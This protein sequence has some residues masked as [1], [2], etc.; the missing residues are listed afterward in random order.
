MTTPI[1]VHY[2]AITDT[3][4]AVAAA[5]A[6]AAE[7]GP[8]PVASGT[9][10]VDAAAAAVAAQIAQN[11]AAFSAALAPKGPELTA[12]AHAAVAG[13]QSTDEANSQRIGAVPAEPPAVR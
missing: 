4:A 11:V 3:A 12:A 7:P 1:R 9:S 6:E 10:P 13:L 8:V 5:L 2:G